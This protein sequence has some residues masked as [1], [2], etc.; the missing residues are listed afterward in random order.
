VSKPAAVAKPGSVSRPPATTVSKPYVPPAPEKSSAGKWIG[1]GVAALV[2]VGGAIVALPRLT[3]QPDPVEVER[4][5]VIEAME[6][7]RTGYRTKNLGAAAAVF[8]AMPANLRTTMEREF[9]RCL[10][11]ELTFSNMQV[12]L[13][14]DATQATVNVRAAHECT[15]NSNDPQT[16]VRRDETFTLQRTGENWLIDSVSSSP[17]R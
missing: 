16:T 17:A 2:I 11:Y 1:I 12:E 4:P 3:E 14:P 6:R 7:F 5:R 13:N 10:V 15:P 9:D 8:T